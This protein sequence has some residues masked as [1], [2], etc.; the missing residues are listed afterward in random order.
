[1]RLTR[2]E[3]SGFR[4]FAEKTVLDFDGVSAC[5][6]VGPNGT[7]KSTMFDALLWALYGDTA[8]HSADSIINVGVDDVLVSAEMLDVAGGV[9]KF[10][11]A[12][13][14][15]KASTAEYTAP[16]GRVESQAKNV[17]V[18]AERVMGCS[19]EMWKMSCLARQ[20]DLGR[21]SELS[22]SQ[23]RSELVDLL[24]GDMFDDLVN[25]VDELVAEERGTSLKAASTL[26]DAE[27]HAKDRSDAEDALESAT[28]EAKK[29]ESDLELMVALNARVVEH[30]ADI[31]RLADAERAEA[32]L[33]E[34]AAR[35]EQQ[36]R[37]AEELE[38]HIE[39]H[40]ALLAATESDVKKLADAERTAS[41]AHSS[42]VAASEKAL[43]RAAEAASPAAAAQRRL[44]A[45]VA[46]DG[47]EC[48][49]CGSDLPDDRKDE[50][51]R[52][53]KRDILVARRRDD[54]AEAAKGDEADRRSDL[55]EAERARSRKER[56]AHELESKIAAAEAKLSAMAN[57]SDEATVASELAASAP[58]LREKVSAI[59]EEVRRVIDD[60]GVNDIEVEA[61]RRR[62]ASAQQVIG[63]A[64]ARVVKARASE[65]SL[66]AL[67]EA[68]DNARVSEKAAD[69][70]KDFL[71]PAGIPH[72]LMSRRTAEVER[73]VNAVLASLRTAGEGRSLQMR[74]RTSNP[75]SGNPALGIEVD[76]GDDGWM[77]YA[78]MSGGMRARVDI[79]VRVGL[80]QAAGVR[81][82]MLIIDEGAAMLD[83]E[84][85]DSLLEVVRVLIDSGLL[86]SVF[87]VT[88]D[89]RLKG[90]LPA[91]VEV[92]TD[93][94]GAGTARLVS[95]HTEAPLKK[96]A[97]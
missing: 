4:V 24:V 60:G 41:E 10:V 18:E 34:R 48:W 11:R 88:H 56:F 39:E 21:F 65:K 64:K 40:T 19:K 57:E 94:G 33:A 49:V 16:D 93:E 17:A 23:R 12:R 46:E 76:L 8:D 70:L 75:N 5:T 62:A 7:G 6:V 90:T 81:C 28:D 72:L 84:G 51:V 36:E 50:L 68:A 47:S 96:V 69:L 52:G 67:G 82:R 73:K 87:L 77:D 54:A 1:M 30:K 42:A 89:E 58:A 86:D 53:M 2:L 31:R 38:K 71:R 59:P 27:A 32:E 74:F 44:R 92:G 15:G 25:E 43:R 29:A 3:M 14:R 79:S 63:E 37:D 35:R 97:A 26:A 83:E 45:L 78:Q 80:S 85:V 20:G 91:T 9:H 13:K 61:A 22:P 66:P 55:K 95:T